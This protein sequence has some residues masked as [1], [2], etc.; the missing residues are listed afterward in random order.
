MRLIYPPDESANHFHYKR[1]FLVHFAV[2]DLC[3]AAISQALAVFLFGFDAKYQFSF[4][5]CQGQSGMKIDSIHT[6][7]LYEM[8]CF[9]SNTSHNIA[10]NCGKNKQINNIAKPFTHSLVGFSA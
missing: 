10:S 8:L 2:G 7:R 1:T 9:D 3:R 5:K 6:I 4:S